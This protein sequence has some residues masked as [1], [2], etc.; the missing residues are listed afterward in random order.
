MDDELEYASYPAMSEEQPVLGL[1][2]SSALSP[3]PLPVMA[4][5]HPVHAGQRALHCG[6]RG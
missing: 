3:D 1:E 2:P 5:V 4:E 6:H